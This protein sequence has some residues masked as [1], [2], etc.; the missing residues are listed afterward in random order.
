[1]DEEHITL[2]IPMGVKT[3]AEYFPGFGKKELFQTA[4]GSIVFGLVAF[5]VWLLSQSVSGTVLTILAGIAGSVMMPSR[6]WGSSAICATL[7]KGGTCGAMMP[8]AT[9]GL[10][11][12]HSR[13]SVANTEN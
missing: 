7:A 2:Y 13:G 1:M 9:G 5:L 3:E 6:L 8:A 11:Y 12:S 4:I 10:K